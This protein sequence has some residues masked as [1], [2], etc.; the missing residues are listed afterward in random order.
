[1]LTQLQ[2]CPLLHSLHELQDAIR[3][4]SPA[5]CALGLQSLR[6]LCCADVLDF[7][8]AWKVVHKFHPSLPA[9]PLPAAAWVGLMQAG[10]LDAEV[11]PERATA[12]VAALWTATKHASPV[13]SGM[14]T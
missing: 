3:D 11:Y 5:V 14:K 1:M 13:V 6:S 4:S 12:A 7:Y 8:K 9:H 2:P 10:A